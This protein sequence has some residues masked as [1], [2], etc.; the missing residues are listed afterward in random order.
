[1][2]VKSIV[3]DDE[4]WLLVIRNSARMGFFALGSN[5]KTILGSEERNKLDH[6]ASMSNKY[7]QVAE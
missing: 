5:W 1:L 6:P 2:F 4:N 7:M 3:K